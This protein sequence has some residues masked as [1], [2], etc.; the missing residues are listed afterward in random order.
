MSARDTRIEADIAKINELALRSK[1]QIK[2]LSSTA[3]KIELEFGYKTVSNSSG[4]ITQS[5]KALIELGSRYPFTEPKVKF[6]T[7][8][9]HPNVYDSGQVC[10]GTKWFPTEGLNLL[11]ERLVKILIFD[12]SVINVKPPAS[13]S[14]SNWY[15][16][17]VRSDRS[18]FPTDTFTK[19]EGSTKKKIQW[20]QSKPSVA[21][22]EVACANCKARLK[23]PAGKSGRVNCPKCKKTFEVAT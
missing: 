9:F 12:A 23:V 3:N 8:V 14:A 22:V 6:T 18:F 17:K 13:G 1:G 15:L 4:N 10:L 7:K 2:V 20:G 5:T 11:V 21:R 19:S 16:K